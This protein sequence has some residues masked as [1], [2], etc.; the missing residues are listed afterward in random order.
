[1]I[2]RCQSALLITFLTLIAG[3]PSFTH[4]NSSRYPAEITGVGESANFPAEIPV[5]S[6]QY[7]RGK[8]LM[9]EPE[10]RNYSVAY[11][12]YDA[13]L[14]NAVTLYFYSTPNSF[15]DQ[16][17]L[18]KQE[19]LSAHS[20]SILLNERPLSLKKS[21]K[22]YP[23]FIASFRYE[24]VFAGTRQ[25]VFSQLVFVSLPNHYFKVRSSAPL[26][27]AANAELSMLKLVDKVNWAH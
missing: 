27:Q 21:G 15:A 3:C 6:G 20:G 22:S 1:M 9:Y 16:F 18:L 17:E 14:Q 23:A 2:K 4:I 11:D 26:S 13:S 24:E 8:M 12:C 19:I 10:M 25:S 5:Q 7:H